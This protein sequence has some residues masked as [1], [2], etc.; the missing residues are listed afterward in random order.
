[1]TKQEFCE[2]LKNELGESNPI[3]PETNFKELDSF[4]SLSFVLVMQLIEDHFKIKINP[5]EL[6]SIKTVNDIALKIG[7]EQFN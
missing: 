5:R 4:G 2:I 7:E 6:R 1:M 3:N